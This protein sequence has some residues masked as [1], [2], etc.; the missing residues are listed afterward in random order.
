MNNLLLYGAS[1]HAKVICSIIESLKFTVSGIFDDDQ[2][3]S[4]LNNYDVI[5]PYFSDFQ[6][7]SSLIISIGDN[8]IRKK[9]SDKITH[10][11]CTIVHSKSEID[12]LVKI[13]EGTI[14]MQNVVI[15]RDSI[16]G[17][18]CIINTS[19][20]IDH[21]CVIGDFA[22]ISPSATLCGNVE[23][24]EGTHIGSGATIIPNI[25]IGKWCKIG[26]GGVVIS[27]VP[28]YSIVVGVPG[29][30]IKKSN[31]YK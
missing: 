10:K 2:R 29:K 31:E 30:I 25:K 24:G 16:I 11:F 6:P 17:K 26:A 21:D 7:E 5:G 15:Q 27:D 19:A 4:K 13:G 1:G 8:S 22:H 3:I 9:V 23:I 12:K 20:S 14:V 28:D 18:H